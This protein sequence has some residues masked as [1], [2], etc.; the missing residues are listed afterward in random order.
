MPHRYQDVYNVKK[1][2]RI[3][4][5]WLNLPLNK[6]KQIV[7]GLIHTDGCIGKEVVYDSTSLELIEGLRYLLLRMGIL[8]SGYVRDRVGEKHMTANGMIENKQISYCLRIPKTE[9]ICN[10]LDINYENKQKKF[11]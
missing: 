3:A 1:E 5:K 9:E 11:Y 7:K 2:K 8:T 10:L 6:I 4:S